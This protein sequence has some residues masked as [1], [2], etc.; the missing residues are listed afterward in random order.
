MTPGIKYAPINTSHLNVLD[1]CKASAYISTMRGAGLKRGGGGGG[2]EGGLLCLTVKLQS[3]L[4]PFEVK[5]AA[6]TLVLH[7]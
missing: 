3:L 4:Q 5:Q 6:E 2:G 1:H 7:H